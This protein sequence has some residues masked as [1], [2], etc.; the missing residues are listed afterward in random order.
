[1]SFSRGYC[2]IAENSI[3]AI[4]NL[5]SSFC[6]SHK[7]DDT[8]TNFT[9]TFG[10]IFNPVLPNDITQWIPCIPYYTDGV[11]YKLW[12]MRNGGSVEL[13]SDLNHH[14]TKI[15]SN[16]P[17]IPFAFLFRYDENV[18]KWD[19][20]FKSILDL[21][22][23]EIANK[24]TLI[25]PTFGTNNGISFHDSAIGIFYGLKN[26]LEQ[27]ELCLNS[28]HVITPFNND[29]NYTSCRTIKHLSNMFDIIEST[30][31]SVKASC[32]VCMKNTANILL[33]CGHITM[34]EGCHA[35]YYNDSKIDESEKKCIMCKKIVSNVVQT[36][37]PTIVKCMCDHLENQSNICYIPC[38]HTGVMCLNC[39]DSTENTK[40]DLCDTIIESKKR[41]YI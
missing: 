39:E 33:D 24:V 26:A 23:P 32:L 25:V 22:P 34:C 16:I 30:E 41:V 35:R 10:D 1:M 31:P 3:M 14:A 28:V 29:Q 36:K 27:N 21:I 8:N 18:G 7:F 20:T 13:T 15:I 4:K 2:T 17:N 12:K 9:I 38:G 11:I 5:P 40:C 6:R 37:Y 19:E